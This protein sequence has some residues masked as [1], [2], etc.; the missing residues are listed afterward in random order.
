MTDDPEPQRP[1][2]RLVA[3]LVDWGATASQIV[4]HMEL[5]QRAGASTTSRSTVETFR[6]LLTETLAPV[7]ADRDD[8]LLDHA[9]SLV[10]TIDD[11]VRDEIV[12]VPPPRRPRRSRARRPS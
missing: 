4:S 9:A 6:L 10:A 12:L 11:T 8:R 7:L 3:A 2:E 5:Y 1:V